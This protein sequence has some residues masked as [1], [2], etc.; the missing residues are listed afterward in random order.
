MFKRIG[1]G[2]LGGLVLLAATGSVACGQQTSRSLFVMEE[3]WIDPSLTAEYEEGVRLATTSMREANLGPEVNWEARQHGSSYF[4]IFQVG[5]LNEIDLSSREAKARNAQ[6]ARAM[7]EETYGRFH[8]LTT[9]AIRGNHLSVLEPVDQ[10]SYQAADSA[11]EAP[12]FSHVNILR[13]QSAKLEQFQTVITG[14][15][16]ALEKAE[17]QI[18]FHVYRPVIGDGKVFFDN[19]RTYYFVSPYDSRSQFY[20]E[21][22]I[23]A[24]LVKALGEDGAKEILS[25]LMKCLIEMESF[26]YVIRPDLGYRAT[27]E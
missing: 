11:V 23:G 20:E 15:I 25:D 17:H 10:F 24:S 6:L 26:D 27:N 9:P 2:A 19:A 8:E 21:Y 1:M 4:Y 5:S 13:V 22:P 18:G 3:E 14:I 7:D 16:G 12:E